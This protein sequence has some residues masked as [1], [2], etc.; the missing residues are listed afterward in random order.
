[1]DLFLKPVTKFFSDLDK[2]G[3]E[4]PYNGSCVTV[5]IKPVCCSVDSKARP[6]LL[7]MKQYNGYYACPWCLHPGIIVERNIKYP[8]LDYT[9]EER[10]NSNFIDDMLRAHNEQKTVN[11]IKGPPPILNFCENYPIVSS[12]SVDYLH[13]VCIGE[14]KTLTECMLSDYGKP[15]YIGSPSNIRKINSIL[16]EISFPIDIHR[17]P[18]C[19]GEIK[20]WKASQWLYWIIYCSRPCL[21]AVL[22][23]PFFSHW[24]KFISGLQLLLQDKITFDEIL[25]AKTLLVNF[26]DDVEEYY[27]LSRMT[28]NNH[29]LKHL[30]DNVLRLGPLWSN[31][32]FPFESELYYLKKLVHNGVGALLQISKKLSIRAN[33]MEIS[34]KLVKSPIVLK[35]VFELSHKSFITSSHVPFS[36]HII[37]NVLT[38]DELNILNNCELD[39]SNLIMYSSTTLSGKYIQPFI[40]SK[41]QN[42]L[43]YYNDEHIIIH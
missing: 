16:K 10:T 29:I 17:E 18:N 5:K 32:T 40:N 41:L 42:S 4:V 21:R 7:N 30:S 15:Y 36:A 28:F 37:K 25:H 20:D 24:C 11:G 22:A 39:V 33:F 14:G 35:H 8:S 12:M 9:V 2:Y 43:L 34:N 13:A 19:I 31:S 38:L 26:S 23:E 6:L 27:G 1:M 3:I